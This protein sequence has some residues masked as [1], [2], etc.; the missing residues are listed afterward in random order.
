MSHRGVEANFEQRLFGCRQIVLC[1]PHNLPQ[2]AHKL[3]QQLA[4]L[5]CLSLIRAPAHFSCLN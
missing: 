5:G 1:D 2:D 4:A 3:K